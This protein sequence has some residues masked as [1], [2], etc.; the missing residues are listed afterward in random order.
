MKSTKTVVVI[1]NWN[2]K[3]TI[4]ATLDS[5]MKQGHESEIVVVDNGSIDGSVKYLKQNYSSITL[6]EHT[7]NRGFAGGVNAGIRRAIENNADYV[8]LLNN[9]AVADQSWLGELVDILDS[10]VEV[11]IAAS[12]M[13]DAEGKYIDS[14]GDLYTVWGLPFPRGRSEIVSDKYDDQLDIFAGSGGA[15]LYRVEMLK[16]IGLFDENFFA[17]YEDVDLSFRAQLT[18]WK[19][20]YVPTAIAYHQIGATS[21]K[22]KG[23]TTYQTLKNLPLLFWKNVPI[24]LMPR[25]MPRLALSDTLFF[26]SAVV[27]G[28]G[29]PALKGVVIA[30]LLIPKK[31]LERPKRTVSVDYIWNMMTHDLPPNAN[32]LRELRAKWWRITRR[33][34]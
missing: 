31:L 11:G 10:N 34:A 12:K 24:S 15:S 6:I 9:D 17:Y 14:T 7:K 21:S 26:F 3:D 22:I 16:Q 30:L 20:R 19:V 28:Q 5:L 13:L 33:Q 18:G 8:A 27:R 1:P 4:R 29:W 23:F 32:R 25:V 2:G